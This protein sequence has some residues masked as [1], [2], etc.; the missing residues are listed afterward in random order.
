M[1][2]YVEGMRKDALIIMSRSYGTKL[3]PNGQPFLD[4]YLLE[5]L[6]K[7][8]CF[9]DEEEARTAC[10]H[11]GITV[12]GDRVLWRHSKFEE[13]RDPDKGHIIPLKPKKMIRTIESKLH[14][15]TRLT[16]CRGGVSGEGATL[17]GA[18][19]GSG[20]AAA[21][22]DH[23]KAQENAEKERLEVMK[24]LLESE[25]KGKE[26]EEM[27]KM[28][29]VKQ[30][31]LAAE[32]RVRAEAVKRAEL[33]KLEE[34]RLQRERILAIQR[35]K[36]EEARRLAEAEAVARRAE[37]ERQEREACEREAAR[38]KAEEEKM[39][40]ERQRLLAKQRENEARRM[41]QAKAAK[42]QAAKEQREREE[43]RRLA[44]LRKKAEEDRI[45]KAQEEEAR[46]IEM[47]WC[48]KI[49][50]ARK[51]LVWR[52][53]RKQMHRRESLEKSCE[54]LGRL[55]PTSTKCP[56]PLARKTSKTSNLHISIKYAIEAE[57]EN[58]IFRLATASRQP[59]DLSGMVARSLNSPIADVYP[60][61]LLSI[62]NVILFKLTIW[63]PRRNG[64]EGLYDS[65]RMWV[66]SH[67][68]VGKVYAHTFKRRSKNM[69]IRVVSVI[70]N[71]QPV[72]CRDYNAALLLRPST[73]GALS[74]IEFPEEADSR[75]VLDLDNENCSGDN[76]SA[77][78]ILGYHS[79]QPSHYHEGVL[80]RKLCDF[81]RAFEE[82]CETI[83]KSHFEKAASDGTH[84]YS[85][86]ATSMARMSIESFGFLCLQ[87]LMQ[88][89]DSEGCFRLPSSDESIFVSC[90]Q[91]L[92]LLVEELSHASN[93]AHSMKQNWPPLE[94]CD[95][96]KNSVP[97]YFDWR[98]DLP[99]D[100]H[101]PLQD[102]SRKVFDVFLVLLDRASFVN[103][104]E[105]IGEKLP[106]CLRQNLFNMIDNN[107]IPRC[108]ADVVSF[109]V[110]GELCLESREENIIYLPVET[111]SQIIERVATYDA[112]YVPDRVLMDIPSYLFSPIEIEQG[113]IG[114]EKTTPGMEKVAIKRKPPERIESESSGRENGKRGRTRAPLNEESEEQR[115]SK[116]FTLLLEALL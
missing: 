107:D 49:E 45:R 115:R 31:K 83:V 79:G 3:K 64:I 111:V 76:P 57:L 72:G 70:G 34:E 32:T 12:E 8:L 69:H 30:E 88:N 102:I 26:Q 65:L 75:T 100:W 116:E 37:R 105:S 6:V 22:M 96:E 54:C 73:T 94:F 71:E 28:E 108:F 53:W 9:E 67:L 29:R 103:F 66:N 68:R 2:K 24:R 98:F 61:G 95:K 106:L 41:A 46:R 114:G 40:R 84:M 89:M 47:M 7:L 86:G 33:M 11:Y 17:S 92:T 35:Q 36:E 4:E 51:I 48:E 50:K 13:P 25:A 93:E 62:S 10:C 90:K 23:E 77:K 44:E 112:P 78:S 56:T 15:A 14:G 21:K 52:L 60:P 101:I 27:R 20:E 74:R 55:D 104:V 63:L 81:D 16:V 42:E 97:A 85:C 109:V 58:Q 1:F 82:C 113:Q 87:R 59:I 110:N 43:M 99:R 39:E 5:D 38:K 18:N 80:T 19:P 91:T